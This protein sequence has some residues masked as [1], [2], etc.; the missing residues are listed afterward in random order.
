M[1]ELRR[2]SDDEIQTGLAGLPGWERDG[3]ELVVTFRFADFVAAFEFMT[4]C[5][6]LAE[7][8]NHH[9]DWRNIY[10]RVTIRLTTHDVGGLSP[11]DLEFAERAS[12]LAAHG[13]GTSI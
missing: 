9:P 12:Q 1:G 8:L 2:A 13:G 11:Y 7:E 3:D 4:R 5:A 6:D 10:S